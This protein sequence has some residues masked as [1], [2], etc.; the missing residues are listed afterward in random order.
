MK[1]VC[2]THK[3]GNKIITPPETLEVRIY[4]TSDVLGDCTAKEVYLPEKVNF[5]LTRAVNSA[6]E[7]LANTIK[8]L[9]SQGEN[10]GVLNFTRATV[11]IVDKQFKRKMGVWFSSDDINDIMEA[12]LDD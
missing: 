8:S 3:K 6:A 9:E 1:I 2:N 10:V 11:Q 5:D 12:M 7:E 4:F